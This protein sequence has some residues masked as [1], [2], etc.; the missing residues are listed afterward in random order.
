MQTPKYTITDWADDGGALTYRGHGLGLGVYQTPGHT[1]DELALWDP[2]ERTLYVG[3]SIYEWAPIIFP[4][5]GN[6]VTYS[7][8]MGQLRGLVKAWNASIIA[9]TTSMERL[10]MA[11]GH[12]TAEANAESLLGE[13]DA[14]LW[15]VVS[16]GVEAGKVDKIRGEV[17]YLYEREDGRLSFRGP[18]RLFDEFRANGKA[19]EHLKKRVRDWSLTS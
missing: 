15:D 14:F 1:P 4:K 6:L 2:N 12:N 11:C 13:V 3:D 19:M 7:R 16:G 18:R 8:S 17:T 10:V 9:S 5:E